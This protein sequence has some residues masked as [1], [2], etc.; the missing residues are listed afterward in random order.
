[1][2]ISLGSCQEGTAP[3]SS[4]VG[5]GEAILHLPVAGK[6][7]ELGAVGTRSGCPAA[8]GLFACDTREVSGTVT[9]FLQSP[10]DDTDD[11]RVGASFCTHVAHGGSCLL[12]NSELKDAGA[13]YH[14]TGRLIHAVTH[15]KLGSS[16]W[17]CVCV[18]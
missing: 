17:T 13:T 4:A 18:V 9:R 7:A 2:V 10:D 5:V 12:H 6:Q 3:L 8:A 15:V 11:W 14:C 16:D 1:M